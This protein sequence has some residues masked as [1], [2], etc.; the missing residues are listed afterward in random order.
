MSAYLT[1]VLSRADHDELLRLSAACDTGSSLFRVER[2]PDFFAFGDILG[3]TRYHG[4][5]H[6]GALVGCIAL[7]AQ[8]RFIAREI[9]RVAYLH[10]LRVHPAHRVAR[11]ASQLLDNAFEAEGKSERWAFA[12]LLDS[13]PHQASIVRY[14][15]RHFGRARPL[16]RTAHVGLPLL[17]FGA[18]RSALRVEELSE[19]EWEESYFERAER[20]D[21]ASAEPSHWRRLEGRYLAVFRGLDL[22]ALCKAVTSAEARNIVLSAPATVGERVQRALL[23]CALAVPLPD[24]GRRLSHGYLAFHVGESGADVVTAFHSYI[25]RARELRWSWVFRGD[26]AAAIHPRHAFGIRFTSST[27]GF[28]DVPPHLHLQ[29]H[30]LTLI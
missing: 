11:V 20:R 23:D 4:V 8:R 13:N 18:R 21:L 17:R 15:E 24:S 16:G 25:A 3:Q 1:R 26:S 6:E 30:E 19:K 12:T 22:C 14:A 5:F 2:A 27:F 7:T 28:G 9:R 29:A 10:D